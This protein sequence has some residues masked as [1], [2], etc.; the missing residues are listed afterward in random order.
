MIL[1]RTFP[2][3]KIEQM[4]EYL[5]DKYPKA[6]FTRPQL[7]RP[8]KRNIVDDLEKD[9]VLDQ[10]RRN[11]A[12]SFYTQDWNYEHALQVGAKRVDLS[13]KEI[14]TV[15]QLEQK[16]AL[17]RVRIKKAALYGKSNPIDVMRQLHAN[18]QISTD[19]L[20]KITAPPLPKD[21]PPMM[22]S[23]TATPPSAESDGTELTQLRALWGNIDGILMK[24]ED[25]QLQAAL[26][27]PALKVFIAEAEKLIETLERAGVAN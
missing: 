7:K 10:E 19:Q 3:E 20:S 12:I 9:Q 4:I 26:A 27:V 17:D 18:G 11:A 13:G 24:A 8:L 1:G 2:R 15:T 21:D 6:F 22:K 14:G 16:E 25:E 23:K 5:A